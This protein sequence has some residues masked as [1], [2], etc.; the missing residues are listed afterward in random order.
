MSRFYALA[1]KLKIMHLPFVNFAAQDV[2]EDELRTEGII[3]ANDDRW[4]SRQKATKLVLTRACRLHLNHI[5]LLTV[6][7]AI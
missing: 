4:I 1:S 3:S 2:V 5:Y 6:S 7:T